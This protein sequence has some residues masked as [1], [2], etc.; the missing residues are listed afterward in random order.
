MNEV[1][2]RSGE[3]T[4]AIR[5]VYA[6]FLA[7]RRWRGR[8]K[9]EEGARKDGRSSWTGCNLEDRRGQEREAVEYGRPVD[10]DEA[11]CAEGGMMTI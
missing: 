10:A 6:K 2:L 11:R 8:R 1:E 9:D 4:A 3:D 7:D 5:E